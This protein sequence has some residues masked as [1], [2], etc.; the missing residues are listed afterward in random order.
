M[1]V[2]YSVETSPAR[3]NPKYWMVTTPKGRTKFDTKGKAKEYL[4]T[5]D[6]SDFDEVS[7][8]YPFAFFHLTWS[9]E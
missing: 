8:K 9:W 7:I 1:S 3:G 5:L 6:P 4:K 2:K